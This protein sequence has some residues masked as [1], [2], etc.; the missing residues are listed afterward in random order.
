M[1][2]DGMCWLQGRLPGATRTFPARTP[3]FHRHSAMLDL[4]LHLRRGRYDHWKAHAK[5]WARDPRPAVDM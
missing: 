5:H 4:L 1:G 2:C 3:A